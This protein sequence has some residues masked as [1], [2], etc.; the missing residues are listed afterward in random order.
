MFG[1]PPQEKEEVAYEK[2]QIQKE[3]REK[4]PPRNNYQ[5]GYQPGG[6]G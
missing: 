6:G 2:K 3:V 4:I 1:A 5:G